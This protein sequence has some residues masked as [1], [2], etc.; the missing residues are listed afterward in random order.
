MAPHQMAF[1]YFNQKGKIDSCGSTI[2]GLKIGKWY[3]YGDSTW[4]QVIREYEMGKL[5]SEKP[6]D[7]YKRDISLKPG[8]KEAE[9]SGGEKSWK[10]YLEKNLSTP[11]RAID[12][13]VK[14]TVMISFTVNISGKVEDLRILKSV[15]YSADREAMRV[16]RRS[17]MW[18][19]AVQ[20]GHLK[21]A[22]RIQPITFYN[23]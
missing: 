5:I 23:D 19:P 8:E 20:D 22:Y 9:F 16:I 21:N 15:E 17:P 1:A 7:P 14:G 2:K 18:D 12:L 6:N 13:H 4:P 11:D 3:Y 10:K